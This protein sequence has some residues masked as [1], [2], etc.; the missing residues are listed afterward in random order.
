MPIDQKNQLKVY[1]DLVALYPDNE[2]YLKKYAEL[3]LQ[4]NKQATATEILR[5]LYTRLIERGEHEKA[6]ALADEFP[7]IGRI[8]NS[9]DPHKDRMD[10]LLPATMRNRLWLRLHQHKLREGRHLIHRGDHEDTVYLVCEGELAEFIRSDDGKPVLL[11]LIA[12]GNVVGESYL[13]TPGPHKSDVVANKDSIIAKLPRKKMLAALD[14]LPSLKKA[15]QRKADARRITALISASPLL[16]NVP[17]DMRKHMA[18]A[19]HLKQ[20]PGGAMIHKAGDKLDHVDLVVKGVACFQMRNNGTIKELKTLVPGSFVGESSAIHTQGCPAD[21]VANSSVIIAHIA[22]SAFKN[23]VEAYPPLRN[24]L[25]A[26][27][28]RNQSQIMNRLNELQT[29]QFDQ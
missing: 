1:A 17:L 19:T 13:F 29:Q 28:E 7:Q 5:Q 12:S 11:N 23:V 10:Q 27:I 14:G 9:S 6:D 26:Y 15:L 24:A 18:E 16:Q 20:Y 4:T 22:Y 2:S 21:M 8:R 3:L 25:F